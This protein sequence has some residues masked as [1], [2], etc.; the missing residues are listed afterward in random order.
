MPFTVIGHGD[1]QPLLIEPARAARVDTSDAFLLWS[2]LNSSPG[3]GGRQRRERA[4]GGAMSSSHA[5]APDAPVAAAAASEIEATADANGDSGLG[6]VAHGS[7]LLS[8]FI[9][10][11]DNSMGELFESHYDEVELGSTTLSQSI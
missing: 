11:A 2:R 8:A 7:E 3:L 4:S 6:H 10:V 9:A 5:G 1:E